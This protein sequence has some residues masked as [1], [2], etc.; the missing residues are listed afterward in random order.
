[1]LLINLMRYLDLVQVTT[2]SSATVKQDSESEECFNH[3][4]LLL[5]RCLL[6]PADAEILKVRVKVKNGHVNSCH[7]CINDPCD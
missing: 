7:K 6:L 5:Y 2:S 4:M 1:M 3:V